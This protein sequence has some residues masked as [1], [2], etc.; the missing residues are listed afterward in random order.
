[1]KQSIDNIMTKGF[2]MASTVKIK[3][4][5]NINGMKAGKILKIAV[6]DYG[7]PVEAYWRRRFKDMKIDRCIEV[8]DEPV[9]ETPVQTIEA[10]VQS[11]EQSTP[12]SDEASE[13]I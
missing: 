1:M 8:V 7:T 6:D 2:R 3:L 13:T 5:K 11:D 4:N 12:A 9:A 10:P